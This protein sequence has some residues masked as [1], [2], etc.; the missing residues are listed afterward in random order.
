MLRQLLSRGQRAMSAARRA[1]PEGA[2][3]GRASPRA[4]AS[5]PCVPRDCSRQH[6]AV[7]GPPGAARARPH[8]GCSRVRLLES[9]KASSRLA[10]PN[11][12][13]SGST[14][15][16]SY[17]AE[18]CVGLRRGR[19]GAPEV[20]RQLPSK[21]RALGA[22]G[23]FLGRERAQARL[24]GGELLV[25][26]IEGQDRRPGL[27]G[28]LSVL[29]T[30]GDRDGARPARRRPGRRARQ[31]EHDE[32]KQA[33][34][35]RVCLPKHGAGPTVFEEEAH[36]SCRIT[37]VSGTF[38]VDARPATL[39]A[40][41]TR[42]VPAPPGAPVPPPSWGLLS[43]GWGRRRTFSSGSVWLSQPQSQRLR[44][45]RS[46]R[47][48]PRHRLSWDS[49]RVCPTRWAG[50]TTRTPQLARR[51]GAPQERHELNI[52]EPAGSQRVIAGGS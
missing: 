30:Q 32:R 25:E 14:S 3:R 38:P 2:R 44:T 9:R 8:Q 45:P 12:I 52:L 43:V 15:P 39:L 37:Q 51:N 19:P 20:D 24:S 23:T 42:D 5:A 22:E 28:D 35:R 36:T 16:C 17:R 41:P 46:G 18:P 10:A 33:P 27:G 1:Q 11:T 13:S 34:F 21:L 48:A 49:C 47:S 6:G 50:S 29:R 4:V 40:C 26:R 31:R 7:R